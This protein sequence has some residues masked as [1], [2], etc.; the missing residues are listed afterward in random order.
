M[1]GSG[2]AVTASAW[3]V[4]LVDALN[5]IRR[6][7]AA[8]PG[9]DGPERAEEGRVACVQSLQR[10]LR[11]GSPTHAVAVFE[12]EGETWRHRLFAGYKAGH[13]PMPGALKQAL[14]GYEE[15]FARVGVRSFRLPGVEADD[16]IGTLATKIEQA[17]GRAVILSTDKVFL[18]LLSSLV[19]VRD[20]F[21]KTDLDRAWVLRRFGVPPERFADYLA[22]TGD[23]GNGI[24]GV[25]GV[26]PKTAVRLITDFDSLDAALAATGDGEG[27]EAERAEA[28]PQKTG[29]APARRRRG[30]APGSLVGRPTHRSRTGDQPQVA[31]LHAL[32]GEPRRRTPL[33]YSLFEGGPEMLRKW[34]PCALLAALT[35]LPLGAELLLVA[36]KSDDTVDLVDLE[37]GMS[38]ATLP[39]GHAP[40]EVAVSTDGSTAVITNYGD[41]ERPGSS[42][43]VL[44]LRRREVIRTVD[45]APHTRPHGIVWLP[46][47]RLAVTTE[48]SRHLLVVDPFSGTIER[49]IETGQEI[50]HMVAVTPDGRRGFV[51]NIGSGTVTAIDLEA[52]RKLA[53]IATGEGAEGIAV[54][55]SGREVWVGN[56]ASDTLTILDATS[57]EI[58]AQ[59]PCPGFP[60]RV[61]FTPGGERV[62]VSAARSGEVVVFDAAERRELVRRK[63]DLSTVPTAA[64]RL[65]GDRFGDSPVPVGLVVSADGATAWVAATQADVVVTVRTEDLTVV[66]LIRTGEEPDGMALVPKS[67]CGLT[68]GAPSA[69]PNGRADPAR[70]S[71]AAGEESQQDAEEDFRG[72]RAVI[73][74]RKIL[75]P[76]DFSRCAEQA[77]DYALLLAR[78]FDAELHMLHA[79]VFFE[80]DPRNV[81]GQFPEEASLVARLFEIADSELARQATR[82]DESPIHIHRER[83]KG[84][85]A[86]E[87]ILTYAREI[88]ADLIV[89][90]T[91]GHRGAARFVLGSVAEKVIR[92]AECP[93]L[94]LRQSDDGKA[95]EAIDKI[96]APVDFSDSS[97]MGVETAKELGH[98]LGASVQLLHVIDV[99]AVPTFYGPAAG[100]EFGERLRK[101]ALEHM[102]DLY[103]GAGGPDGE[104]ESFVVSGTPSVRIAE[105]ADDAGQRSDRDPQSRAGRPRAVDAR[106][107]R[108][109]RGTGRGL[110]GADLEVGRQEPLGRGRR[111]EGLTASS[112]GRCP[113]L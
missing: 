82:G 101:K 113:L 49:R 64:E 100:V 33:V 88:D 76:T 105:I 66:D 28:L 2:P 20:H 41:R 91:H 111:R 54:S 27:G 90:G 29:G 18:Q 56:R 62:L 95:L 26:G 93:V 45:L 108:R 12:G 78:R 71:L 32:I 43:T 15:S 19:A 53:D 46:G 10:A 11:E 98:A 107:H 84:Y 86:N 1:D 69:R 81:K 89:M 72:G 70:R 96:L 75:F 104:F 6:V 74:I 77:L 55:P 22:L 57:L 67:R 4:L 58:L 40:H 35:T 17:G 50:A 24:P 60:I 47:G 85:S 25:S 61:T 44:D 94:T 80:A 30:G 7:Y 8:Q 39:T 3:R 13:A 42:L 73:R 79:V 14:P 23:S 99:Q 51:A 31:A 112:R 83:R 34:I 103:A 38:I 9:E 102:A 65:F 97:S 110:S 36:N 16:V 63:L 5:L 21:K 109:A 59:L 48:G 37:S 68:E 92:A 106:Q 87:E 52:G